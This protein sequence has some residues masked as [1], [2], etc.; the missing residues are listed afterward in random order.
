M[1][2]DVR[3]KIFSYQSAANS[4]GTRAD[5]FVDALLEKAVLPPARRPAELRVTPYDEATPALPRPPVVVA[6][7]GG[8]GL[9]DAAMPMRPQFANTAN[10]FAE[11]WGTRHGAAVEHR[12]AAA[13]PAAAGKAASG[14]VHRRSG[15]GGAVSPRSTDEASCSKPERRRGSDSDLSKL[16]A[17]CEASG[18][19]EARVR[20]QTIPQGGDGSILAGVSV[21]G[22]MGTIERAVDSVTLAPGGGGGGSSPGEGGGQLGSDGDVCL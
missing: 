1:R 22:L 7:A 21:D 13:A 11:A 14:K 20:S 15:S 17:E 2:A 4:R 6:G 8:G 12:P 3:K 9:D 18:G 16:A 5:R 19:I 10:V